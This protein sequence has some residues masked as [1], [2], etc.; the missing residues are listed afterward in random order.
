LEPEVSTNL[1]AIPALS[2]RKSGGCPEAQR[3]AWPGRL[4]WPVVVS[5]TGNLALL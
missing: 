4:A 1:G 3:L 5:Q 2:D